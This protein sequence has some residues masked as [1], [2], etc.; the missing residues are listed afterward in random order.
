MTDLLLE[1]D[2]NERYEDKVMAS[3]KFMAVRQYCPHLE[4]Q[5]SRNVFR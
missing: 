4:A 5:H 1:R 2:S 3:N